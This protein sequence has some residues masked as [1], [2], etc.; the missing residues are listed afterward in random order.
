[1]T[2]IVNGAS[3][4]PLSGGAPKHIVLLLH[5]FGSSGSD[6]IAL[7]PAWQQSLPDALFLAPHAPER[8]GG[9]GYQW[10]G[11]ANLTPQA[12]AAGA[13]GAAPA[14]D[15]FI[16]RK[17]AQ[18]GLSEADL[19]IVGFSQGTMMALQVGLRRPRTVAGI[20][21]YSGMLTGT[22]DLKHNGEPKP[23]VLLVHGSADPVVPVAALHA[24]ESELK[25]LGVEV[26]SHVSPGIGH[27]VDPVG[28]R[29]G[30]E[31]VS[32]VLGI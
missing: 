14:I 1:M 11:L 17:L 8:T 6:M 24:G 29:L 10:W 31:F 23:P 20:V 9:G 15:A 22:A 32:K 3:L 7:A 30:L 13:H 12:L 26:T 27:S 16:D 21:G 4:Q 5:G 19:A 2:K 18:Y 28:L 25:R